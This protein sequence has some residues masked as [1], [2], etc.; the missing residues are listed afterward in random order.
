[1]NRDKIVISGLTFYGYHGVQPEEKVLG[2]RFTADVEIGLDLSSAGVTDDL[3]DTVNYAEVQRIVGDTIEGPARNL[4][5][6]VAE[7]IA[8]SLLVETA[9]QWVMVRLSKPSAPIQGTATG[10]VAVEIRRERSG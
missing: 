10:S 8:Q 4:I 9:A 3:E 2:Q 1:L 7:Q 5:E 6:A